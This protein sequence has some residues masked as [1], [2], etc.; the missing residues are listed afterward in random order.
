MEKRNVKRLFAFF[1]LFLPLQ[2]GMVGILGV[3]F[4]EPWPALVLPG[5]KNIYFKEDRIELEEPQIFAKVSDREEWVKISASGLFQGLQASQ[6]QGFL[7]A[8][9]RDPAKAAGFSIEGKRWL[10]DRLQKLH[11]GASYTS[12]KIEWQKKVFKFDK[13]DRNL[14]STKTVPE[15]EIIIHLNE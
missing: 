2:Y 4:R 12:L 9:F 15:L 1:I 3:L 13:G 5:F 8:N 11:P 14:D 10:S 7:F 6:L